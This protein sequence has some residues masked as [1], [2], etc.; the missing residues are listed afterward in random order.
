MECML[1]G[2]IAFWTSRLS[3][4]DLR[5]GNSLELMKSLETPLFSNGE[6]YA[7]HASSAIDRRWAI[8]LADRSDTEVLFGFSAE[9]RCSYSRSD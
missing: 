4:V 6:I 8:N 1:P 5:G 7:I 9:R 2:R 3:I